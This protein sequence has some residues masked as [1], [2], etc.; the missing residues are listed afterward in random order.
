MRYFTPGPSQLYPTVAAHF[1][2]G[3]TRGVGSI[4]HRSPAFMDTVAHTKAQLTQLLNIP[5]DYAIWFLSSANEAWERIAQNSIRESSFHLINGNFSL[6]FFNFVTQYG[7]QPIRHQV[8]FGAGFSL[9]NIVVPDRAEL[10]AAIA[11]ETSSGVETPPEHIYRLAERNS[12]KLLVVDCV[13]AYPTYALDLSRVDGAY[14]SVQKG[15]GMPA[16]L[17]VLLAG[18]R[19]LDRAQALEAEKIVTGS[20]HRF[21]NLDKYGQKDQTPETPNALSIYVLGRLAEDMNARGGIE[22]IRA[23]HAAKKERLWEYFRA[24]PGLEY[25][26]P[27]GD[28]SSTVTVLN[29]ASGSQVWINALRKKGF[30]VGAGYGGYKEKQLRIANFPATSREDVEDL[31]TA[32]R[33]VAGR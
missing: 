21:T 33:E 5:D 9:D 4:S 29:A 28:R 3:L 7:K 13:S 14:F 26:I 27:V 24:I 8:R 22:E 2:T 32:F 6:K 15:F 20:Y 19:L 16:G 30:L 25:A 11:N 1:E 10:I 18:P 17:G 23:V 12:E 31:L